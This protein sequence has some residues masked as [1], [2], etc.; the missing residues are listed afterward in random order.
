MWPYVQQWNLN[1]QRELS[2]DLV[3]GLAYVGSKGTHLTAELQINQLKPLSNPLPL[4]PGG[5][6]PFLLG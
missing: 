5:S 2:H 4:V 1:V 6:N 3:G